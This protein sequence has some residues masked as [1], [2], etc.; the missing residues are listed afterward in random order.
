M[1]WPDGDPVG[2]RLR[3]VHDDRT[4]DVVGVVGDTRYRNPDARI[5]PMVYFSPNDALPAGYLLV[6]TAA[7]RRRRRWSPRC[8]RGPKHSTLEC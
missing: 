3:T 2:R 7:P 4:F 6:Q 8:V 5:E 1:L